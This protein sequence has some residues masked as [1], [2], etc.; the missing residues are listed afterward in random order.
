MKGRDLMSLSGLDTAVTAL[1]E[2][3]LSER[4]G[5]TVPHIYSEQWNSAA[6]SGRPSLWRSEQCVVEDTVHHASALP[7]C[8][9]RMPDLRGRKQSRRKVRATTA[10]SAQYGSAV[11]ACTES[12]T[13]LQV[14]YR[15]V[16]CVDVSIQQKAQ[17]LR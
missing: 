10:V 15:I 1:L 6:T 11:I 16:P 9:L 14:S 12:V 4:G 8:G 17:G 13:Q 5:H 7:Q 3:H 2:F